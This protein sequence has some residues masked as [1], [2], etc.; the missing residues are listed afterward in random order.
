MTVSTTYT[1]TLDRIFVRPDP[2]PERT[3]SG[4]LLALEPRPQFTGTVVAVGEGMR[5]KVG[6]L[7]PHAV[8]VGQRI[9][10]GGNVGEELYFEDEML[11]V[12][13]EEDVM[14]VLEEQEEWNG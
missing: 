13:R 10:F 3:A 12:M 2:Q 9:V 1:P 4:I 14:A 8:E 6:L 7:L 5:T 11:F